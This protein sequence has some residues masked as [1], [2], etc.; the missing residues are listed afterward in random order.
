M[1][2]KVSPRQ[3]E[4]RDFFA[5]L[6]AALARSASAPW[7]LELEFTESLAMQ[8]SESVTADLAGLR[9]HGISIA[10][11][12]FGSGYSN[13]ARARQMP[14]DR[15]KLDKGLVA[16]IDSSADARD[17]VSAVIHL[18]HGLGCEAVVE[19]VERPEQVDVLR[20]VGCDA[21]QG[22]PRPEPMSEGDFLRWLRDVEKAAEARPG[23][24]SA[25][26]RIRA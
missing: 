22:F 2:L 15:V 11:D 9:D 19:G 20:A 7:P 13:L 6:K 18:V 14:I 26:R 3:L 8:C 5:R 23:Q 10:I 21:I 4:R 24:R 17:I 25:A 16:E 1:S 12:R